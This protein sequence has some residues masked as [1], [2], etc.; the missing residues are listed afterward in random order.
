MALQMNILRGKKSR[1]LDREGRKWEASAGMCGCACGLKAVG[2]YW[3][4]PGGE[5]GGEPEGREVLGALRGHAKATV[6]PRTGSENTKK[7]TLNYF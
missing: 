4:E 2:K 1:S 7:K 3:Q 6:V 5:P